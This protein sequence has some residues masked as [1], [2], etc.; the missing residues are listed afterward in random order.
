MNDKLDFAIIEN[1]YKKR[2]EQMIENKFIELR[3]LIEDHEKLT[4][5]LRLQDLFNSIKNETDCFSTFLHEFM[6]RI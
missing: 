2:I 4:D 5:S 6:K 1:E 3:L